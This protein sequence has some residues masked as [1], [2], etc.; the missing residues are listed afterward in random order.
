MEHQNIVMPLKDTFFVLT[1][2]HINLQFEKNVIPTD[3]SKLKFSSNCYLCLFKSVF[4]TFEFGS[5]KTANR[6]PSR[7]I[8]SSAQKKREMRPLFLPEDLN[9]NNE[10]FTCIILRI[11]NFIRF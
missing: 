5:L 6:N 9:E 10:Q 11:D 8:R 1:L 4:M 3:E 7:K 2:T